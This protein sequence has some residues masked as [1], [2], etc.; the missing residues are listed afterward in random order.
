MLNRVKFPG[1]NIYAEMFKKCYGKV[2]IIK[3]VC[4]KY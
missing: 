2:N 4:K 1:G 3:I